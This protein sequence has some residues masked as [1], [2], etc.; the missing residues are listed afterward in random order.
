[1]Q[2]R[3]PELSVNK[4]AK[5]REELTKMTQQAEEEVPTDNPYYDPDL[6]VKPRDVR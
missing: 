2:R 5:Q 4:R 3:V 6:E 1:M